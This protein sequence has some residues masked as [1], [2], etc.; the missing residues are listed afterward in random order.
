MTS[1]KG[2]SACNNFLYTSDTSDIAVN[3]VRKTDTSPVTRVHSCDTS[4]KKNRAK[5]FRWVWSQPGLQ[6]RTSSQKTRLTV[7]TVGKEKAQ[8]KLVQQLFRGSSAAEI[9]SPFTPLFHTLRCV[10]RRPPSS[11]LGPQITT[12]SDCWTHTHTHT[13][14]HLWTDTHTYTRKPN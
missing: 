1:G 10:C 4:H 13:H 5:R 7:L 11:Y 12:G 2:R 3:R 6:N 8:W 14:T 9:V